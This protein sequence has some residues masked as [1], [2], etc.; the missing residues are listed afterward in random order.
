MRLALFIDG[1]FIPERDGA[2]ARFSQ[3]PRHLTRQ[4][5]DLVVFHCY[6]GW[7]SLARIA[8]E[9]FR[10]YF[11]PPE[12][13]YGDLDCLVGL[14]RE[15]GVTMIQMNDAET[16]RRIGFPLAEAVGLK[17]I[18]EAHYH[19]ST[20]AAAL[21]AQSERVQA[22]RRLESDVSSHVDRI[23][24]F[25]EADRDRWVSISGCPPDRITIVPFGVHEVNQ[26]SSARKRRAVAFLGN[27]F[28]E[29]NKRAIERIVSE[30]LP[31]VLAL[32][33]ETPFIVIGDIPE[34][35]R[36]MCSDAGIR[37]IGE[38][39]NPQTW[40]ANAAVGLAPIS[41]GSG[42]RVKILQY[43]AAGIPVV[44]TTI[45]A[46]GLALPAVFIE[47]DPYE[48]A[49]RCVDIL[50]RPADYA[51]SVRATTRQLQ[52]QFLWS[53]IAQTAQRVYTELLHQPAA[54]R[55]AKPS[56]NFTAVPGWIEEVLQKGRFANA[57]LH[58]CDY[59]FGV[60]GSGSLATYQ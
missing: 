31:A 58:A 46:E 22:L 15:A 50:D 44:A 42:V 35:V 5:T 53:H 30:I 34:D 27:L 13:F 39:L 26:L 49:L 11:F 4:G 6:R 37:V 38:V 14:V 54:L 48:A 60:A 33:P 3:M 10:T 41:E 1:T 52:E 55:R 36:L 43:L 23:I 12:V 59:R 28:Y 24:V 8:R 17:I 57:Q 2:S 7:S 29:P 18:Y 19:T 56:D 21:G 47:D 20:L 32:R 40:L 16:I 25:T 9:P 45:A 51:S